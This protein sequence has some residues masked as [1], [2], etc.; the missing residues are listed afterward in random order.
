VCIGDSTAAVNS[1]NPGTFVLPD[2]LGAGGVIRISEQN[3]AGR[4]WFGNSIGWNTTTSRGW[5]ML[6]DASD[7]LRDFFAFGWDA[8][9]LAALSVDINGRTIEPV[10][11]G[12]WTGA[13]A[14]VGSLGSPGNT[15]DSWQ[16]M[17][18]ADANSA[19]D[20]GWLANSQT[21]G[22]PNPGLTLPWT[23]TTPVAMEPRIVTLEDGEFIGWLAVTQA[24]ENVRLTAAAGA[25]TGISPGFDVAAVIDTDADGLPDSWETANGLEIGSIDTDGDLDRDGSSNVAEFFAG[26]AANDPT[27]RFAITRAGVSPDGSITITWPAVAGKLYRISTSPDL[28]LWTLVQP[29]ILATADG[30]LS[31][32][33]NTAGAAG[34]FARV[35]IQP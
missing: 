29:L 6:F 20:F 27:S 25:V 1:M 11:Q 19:S 26:T 30:P 32:T 10:A 3:F 24:A 7:T 18:A 17:G 2:T 13:G 9:S 16:R 33:I 4:S 34:G 5:A 8:V 12:S 35:E 14:A 23:T 22:A 21:L 15:T 31:R 28:A